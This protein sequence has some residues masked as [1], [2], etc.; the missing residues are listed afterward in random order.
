MQKAQYKTRQMQEML[1][2]MKSVE[3]EHF[4]V[5]D[6]CSHMKEQGVNIGTTTVY[7]HLDRMVSEGLVAKYVI[8]GT[9][10]ACFEY[11]GHEHCC[12][13]SCY[14]LKCEQCGKL[15]HLHCDEVKHFID[16]ISKEHDFLMNPARTIFYGLCGE[17]RKA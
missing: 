4:T 15:I 6:I 2:F 5:Q 7:R 3:G 10:S 8:E 16:H 13:N 1:D 11:I 14:H 12:E 9:N 17:C